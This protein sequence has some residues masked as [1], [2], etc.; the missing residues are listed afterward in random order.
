ME[1]KGTLK[2]IHPIVTRGEKNFESRK[3]WLDTDTDSK[4]P[5]VIELQ[6]SGE[7]VGIFDGV[8]VGAAITCHINLK[9]REWVD[10]NHVKNPDCLA[11]VFNTLECWRIDGNSELP[12][13]APSSD[14]AKN[15]ALPD[16]DEDAPF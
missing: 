10:N 13:K 11:K 12:A 6:V 3:I 2:Q 7:K 8:S 14:F 5:Q 16:T 9:G 15:D 4:Y 1:I